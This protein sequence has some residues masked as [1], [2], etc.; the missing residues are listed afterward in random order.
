[1]KFKMPTMF[2]GYGRRVLGGAAV[3][4]LAGTGLD[5]MDG[6]SGGAM[7]GAMI[8][9]LAGAGRNTWRLGKRGF[10]AAGGTWKGAMGKAKAYGRLG[11][12][13]IPKDFK[14][15]YNDAAGYA[16]SWAMKGLGKTGLYK[17]LGSNSATFNAGLNGAI[18]GAAPG[19]AAGAAYGGF[20]NNES[21][22]SGAFKGAI[23]GATIGGAMK[24]V[25]FTK[26]LNKINRA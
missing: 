10:K 6:T 22:A 8:G 17:H 24:G 12:M 21:M 2:A 25:S 1:M 15:G 13:K 19:L 3:G 4:A 9:A 7:K 23:A 11:R 18:K 16:T 26:T 20:S 5:R 14:T